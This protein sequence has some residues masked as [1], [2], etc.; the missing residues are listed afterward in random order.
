MCSTA[1]SR[2]VLD[3]TEYTRIEN[4]VHMCTTGYMHQICRLQIT[5]YTMQFNCEMGCIS[6]PWNSD[7]RE[8]KK[9]RSR[10]VVTS[11]RAKKKINRPIPQSH[12]D[13]ERGIPRSTLAVA[14]I[15]KQGSGRIL[16]PK[17]LSRTSR[18]CPTPGPTVLLL[19]SMW[20][21]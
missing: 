7:A 9:K 6:L 12:N 4:S 15:K 17:T 1:P 3:C 2:A 5:N 13:T 19:A 20:L 10:Q 16:S 11:I 14:H 8:K 21:L 18:H